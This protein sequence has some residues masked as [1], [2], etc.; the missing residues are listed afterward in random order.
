MRRR[1]FQPIPNDDKHCAG[2][3]KEF[4]KV[5]YGHYVEPNIGLDKKVRICRDWSYS[6]GYGPFGS[7]YRAKESCLRAAR[8]RLELC[9]GCNRP[10]IEPGMMCNDCLELLLK[11]KHEREQE[12]E[13]VRIVRGALWPYLGSKY[14]GFGTE[15]GNLLV[16]ALGGKVNPQKLGF[17]KHVPSRF[18]HNQTH[19]DDPTVLLTEAQTKALDV[20]LNRWHEIFK[21]E[22]A[23]GRADGLSFVMR[24]AEG[25][26]SEK[27]F[28]DAM[29]RVV[30]QQQEARGLLA[31]PTEPEPAEE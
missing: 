21:A 19:Y 2:C 16:E 28:N 27:D 6:G 18:L 10:G 7:N 12:R 17:A 29:A 13:P 20:F 1:N 25:S 8:G 30:R 31:E 14:E 24:M 3:G 15:L 26:V 22:A 4:E 5:V 9:P 11:A 23:D